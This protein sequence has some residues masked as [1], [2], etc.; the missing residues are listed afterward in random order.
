M[1]LQID[2]QITNKLTKDGELQ[3]IKRRTDRRIESTK[4]NFNRL[5]GADWLVTL[6]E[7]SGRIHF[8][9]DSDPPITT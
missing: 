4:F 7:H 2:R 8:S 6:K 9:T 5:A 3:L 1:N